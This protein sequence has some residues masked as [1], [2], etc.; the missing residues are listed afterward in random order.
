MPLTEEQSKFL[1]D[2][3]AVHLDRRTVNHLCRSAC[4]Y[5]IGRSTGA[6]E[7]L[8]KDLLLT[9]SPRLKPGDSCRV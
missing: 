3:L 5:A 2:P 1:F 4:I 8:S 7:A 6:S 9:S